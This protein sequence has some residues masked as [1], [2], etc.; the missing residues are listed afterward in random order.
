[1]N[2]QK[3]TKYINKSLLSVF[4][5]SIRISVMKSTTKTS[6]SNKEI[7]TIFKKSFKECTVQSIEEL[8]DGCF[9]T[10]Y[11]IQLN[12]KNEYVLK[13]SPPEYV[14][15]LTYEQNIM[16][17]EILFHSL[18]EQLSSIPVPR[19]VSSDLTRKLVPYDYF[20]MEKLYGA[21]LNK[22]ENITGGQRRILFTQLAEYLARIHRIKGDHFGYPL[23]K[24]QLLGLSYYKSFVYMV[25]QVFNDGRGKGVKLPIDERKISELINRNRYVFEGIN[26]PVFVHYDLWDGNIF[27]KNMDSSPEIEGLIDFERGYYADP[28]ADFSQISGYIDLENNP[29]FFEAYNKHAENPFDLSG[30]ALIRIKLFRLYLFL[31]MI[32]ETY[33][34]DVDG[35][36]NEQLKWSEDELVKLYNDLL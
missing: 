16:H 13:V 2:I 9:N 36:Y 31:I 19:I 18:S 17:T 3:L 12:D 30:Q 24:K 27:V 4:K 32:V 14:E 8:K 1:M 29:W 5:R 33:Y 6:L 10:S 20:I 28:A 35:S 26:E 11:L 22:I 25:E 21:P 7:D 34:R 23:M 15:L